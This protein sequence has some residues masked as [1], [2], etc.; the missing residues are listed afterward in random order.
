MSFL[1]SIFD[2]NK[3]CEPSSYNNYYPETPVHREVKKRDKEKGELQQLIQSDGQ[4]PNSRS[5]SS[6]NSV[7]LVSSSFV[8]LVFNS[9]I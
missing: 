2:D 3:T 4:T 5:T 9:A 8:H 1:S 7:G 6:I